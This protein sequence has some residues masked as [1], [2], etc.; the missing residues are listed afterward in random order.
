VRRR[1]FTLVELLVVIGIIAVLIAMLMP[2]LSRARDQAIRIQCMSNLRSMMHAVTMYTSENK[3]YLPY[4]NW[5]DMPTGHTGWLYKSNGP[6]WFPS[7]P[8]PETYAQTGMI[9]H[10]LKT[11]KVFKCPLHD[12]KRTRGPSEVLTSYLMNG[13]VQD[14]GKYG[15]TQR[16][17]NRITK[18]RITDII[19]WESGETNLMNN[20]PPFNDGSSFPGEWLTERHGKGTRISGGGATGS[21]GASVAC[22]GGHA[23]WMS[24]REYDKEVLKYDLPKRDNRFWCAPNVTEGGRGV[25]I[26]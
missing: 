20:G 5:G 9:Y 3:N 11:T 15:P 21:G 1:G 12:E 4:V 10:Y 7:D 23:E 13:A 6:S 14:F 19:F 25:P 22:F 17:P 18:F 2:A 8:P 16:T 26:N 24:L